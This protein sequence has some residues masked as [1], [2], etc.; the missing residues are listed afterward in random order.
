MTQ[1]HNRRRHAEVLAKLEARG[2][3][4]PD[5]IANVDNPRPLA[6]STRQ[7]VVAWVKAHNGAWRDRELIT[8]ATAAFVKTPKYAGALAAEGAVRVSILTGAPVE[9]VSDS[10]RQSAF[11]SRHPKAKGPRGTLDREQATQPKARS[12][13]EVSGKPKPPPQ[14][15]KP[16]APPPSPPAV[17]MRKPAPNPFRRGAPISAEEVERRRQVLASL[18]PKAAQGSAQS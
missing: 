14:V 16:P 4:V 9:P 10:D 5:A 13:V 11:A 8:A 12:G 7:D 18:K 1:N 2:F 6:T 15:P 3:P 17:Q